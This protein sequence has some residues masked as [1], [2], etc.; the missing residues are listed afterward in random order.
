MWY[1]RKKIRLESRNP[2]CSLVSSRCRWP[3]MRYLTCLARSF[4]ICNMPLLEQMISKVLSILKLCNFIIYPEDEQGE[5]E[6]Q[7]IVCVYVCP[8]LNRIL[9]NKN[10][11]L[12]HWKHFLLLLWRNNANARELPNSETAPPGLSKYQDWG[13]KPN[14]NVKCFH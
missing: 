14:V 4:L 12:L 13:S 8:T 11:I 9:S 6:G 3:W 5:R 2:N 10:T 7:S 1:S